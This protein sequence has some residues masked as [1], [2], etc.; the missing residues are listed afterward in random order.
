MQDIFAL[1]VLYL[2]K[3]RL[4]FTILAGL[5]NN[6]YTKTDTNA[7]NIHSFECC[8][9]KFHTFF[10]QKHFLFANVKKKS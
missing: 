7:Q 3:S 9:D 10:Y 6:S 5:R 1:F 4:Q 8:A 2:P